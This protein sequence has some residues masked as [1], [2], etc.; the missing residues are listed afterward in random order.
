[1]TEQ[2]IALTWGGLFILIISI[3]LI[4]ILF[5]KFRKKRILG[6]LLRDLG[7]GAFTATLLGAT[8]NE[9][10]VEYSPFYLSFL[11]IMIIGIWLK[12]NYKNK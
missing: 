5:I 2:S 12:E 8:I 3:L 9:E 4:S 1:M 10:L 6:E 7:L 11:L